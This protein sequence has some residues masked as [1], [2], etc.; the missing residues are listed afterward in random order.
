MSSFGPAYPGEGGGGGGG[1]GASFYD[2]AFTGPIDLTDGTW[3]LNDPD[4]L[5]QSITYSAGVHTVTWNTLAA[6][7]AN[8]RWD[9]GSTHRG[10]RWYKAAEIE[11]TRLTTDDVIQG[12]FY[13]KT[14]NVNR[15]DFDSQMVHGICVDP[16]STVESTIA[17]VGLFASAQ[18]GGSNTFLGIWTINANS[19][20][21]ASASARCMTT[22]Q[23]GGRQAVGGA[24]TVL[25]ASGIRIQNGSRGSSQALPNATD[26]FWIVGLGT[27]SNTTT[28]TANDE[29]QRFSIWRKGVKMDLSGVL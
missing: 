13:A 16:T 7:S 14:D 23:Y 22:V 27:R 12:I 24:F 3:T 18:T 15:G 28:I 26:L 25:D 1:G 21:S 29:S 2:A 11:G 10:P 20:Q 9:T 4:N 8:Y 19:S 17:G 6:G 5:I